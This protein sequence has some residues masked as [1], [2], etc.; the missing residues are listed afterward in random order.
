MKETEILV[1]E[2]SSKQLKNLEGVLS[3]YPILREKGKT[4]FWTIEHHAKKSLGGYEV[5][6]DNKSR[7]FFDLDEAVYY[8]N[9]GKI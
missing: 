4:L 1:R 7:V 8:F 3:R 2:K 5:Q 9:G 6:I